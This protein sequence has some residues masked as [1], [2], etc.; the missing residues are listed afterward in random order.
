MEKFELLIFKRQLTNREKFLIVI[1]GFLVLEI[2]IFKNL[3]QPLDNEILETKSQIESNRKALEEPIKVE[4]EEKTTYKSDRPIDSIIDGNLISISSINNMGNLNK[5]VANYRG[6]EKELITLS[7][8]LG[9]RLRIMDLKTTKEGLEGSFLIITNEK[10][11]NTY[12]KNEDLSEKNTKKI[13]LKEIYFKDSKVLSKPVNQIKLK[14]SNLNLNKEKVTDYKKPDKN[15]DLEKNKVTKEENK[16]NKSIENKEIPL[17]PEE[18]LKEKDFIEVTQYG[19]NLDFINNMNIISYNP[20][21][22]FDNRYV[23]VIF[24]DLKDQR[25]KF[26]IEFYTGNQMGKFGL[27]KEGQRYEINEK[28]KNFELNSLIFENEDKIEGFY[29]E[30]PIE[31]KDPNSFSIER[32]GYEK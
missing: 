18:P 6:S 9:N 26:F 16:T 14:A 27:I 25:G 4:K 19:T 28:Y 1:L 13:N 15:I 7:K 12:K 24:N 10:L 17:V 3:Y 2:L 29:Y 32:Y 31:E 21:F 23:D 8:D 22:M 11:T 5:I 20:N 30:I